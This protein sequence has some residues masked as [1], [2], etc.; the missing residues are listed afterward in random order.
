MLAYLCLYAAR[1]CSQETYLMQCSA[2]IIASSSRLLVK[3]LLEMAE[4]L[5]NLGC[6]ILIAAFTVANVTSVSHFLAFPNTQKAKQT[7]CYNNADPSKK[8]HPREQVNRIKML[9][10]K[11]IDR[12][13]GNWPRHCRTGLSSFRMFCKPPAMGFRV[14]FLP[15]GIT[16]HRLAPWI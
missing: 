6:L 16:A 4:S 1:L 15:G 2:T 5:R 3:S 13:H 11:V 12:C 14:S 7:T 8:P 9:R 10:P